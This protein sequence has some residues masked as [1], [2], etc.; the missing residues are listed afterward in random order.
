[1]RHSVQALLLLG[2]F[3]QNS[4]RSTESWTTHALAVKA[5][6][7]LGIH[8]PS[9]YGHLRVAEKELRSCLWSAVVNQDRCVGLHRFVEASADMGIGCSPLHWASHV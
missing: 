4:Q 3:Q 1:M 2:V 9:S 8:A 5:S 6:Y 7:Q